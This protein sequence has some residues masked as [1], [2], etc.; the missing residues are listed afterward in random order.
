[1]A[2]TKKGYINII[3]EVYKRLQEKKNQKYYLCYDDENGG[4][5]VSYNN[6]TDLN[7]EETSKHLDFKISTY[8][9]KSENIYFYVSLFDYQT[10]KEFSCGYFYIK[11]YS[12]VIGKLETIALYD[13]ISIGTELTEE[14]YQGKF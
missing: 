3:L 9:S 8:Q 2:R 10:K 7:L 12:G 6:N 11:N 1:M 5:D 4:F 14:I 13:I